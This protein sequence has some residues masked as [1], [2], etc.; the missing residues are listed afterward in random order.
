MLNKL[1]ADGYARLVAGA[2][3]IEAD[4]FGEKVLLLP[5]STM[6]KLFRRKRLLSSSAWYPYARRFADNCRRLS[7]LGIPVPEVLA[8]YRVPSIERDAI[9]YRPLVGV[10]ARQRIHG[11]MDE[12]DAAG[13]RAALGRFVATLHA[14]GV[15]FRSLH[16]GNIVLTPTGQTGLIDISDLTI[17]RFG[18]GA[19]AI[20]RNLQHLR[21]HGAEWSWLITD[22]VF[23]DAYFAEAESRG[24]TPPAALRRQFE[25]QGEH[26]S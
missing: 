15:L 19:L 3:I 1:D 13:L 4:G 5:D 8:A 11:R 24:R 10:T 23:R 16:L 17:R 2:T 20:A 18:L 6:V 12:T 14:C 9:H 25:P 26:S 7:V 21:R 22:N